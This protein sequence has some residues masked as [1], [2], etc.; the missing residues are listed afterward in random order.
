MQPPATMACP[1]ILPLKAPEIPWL[2]DISREGSDWKFTLLNR[3]SLP[4][5]ELLNADNEHMISAHSIK[6]LGFM[7]DYC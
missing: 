6:N 4:F 2:G 1:S 7:D 5:T 3:L